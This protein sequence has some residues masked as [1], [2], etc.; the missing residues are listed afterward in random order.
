MRERLTILVIVGTRTDE[1]SL[2]SQ[3]RIGSES[4]CLFRQLDTVTHTYGISR[5]LTPLSAKDV[6]SSLLFITAAFKQWFY[7]HKPQKVCFYAHI[8]HMI[9]CKTM[10]GNKFWLYRKI[11]LSFNS[12]IMSAEMCGR[13]HFDVVGRGRT[14]I[15]QQ[16]VDCRQVRWPVGATQSCFFSKRFSFFLQLF[17]LFVHIFIFVFFV[18]FFCILFRLTWPEFI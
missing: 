18:I 14:I 3:V 16:C 4:H 10:T 17:I 9:R 7:Q 5:K 1:H 12:M 11:M 13:K 15:M 8:T 2:R 6:E